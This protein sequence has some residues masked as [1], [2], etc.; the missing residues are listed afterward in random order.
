MTDG[1]VTIDHAAFVA[2]ERQAHVNA[3][4]IT[5]LQDLIPVAEDRLAWL[6]EDPNVNTENVIVAEAIEQALAAIALAEQS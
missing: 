3:A 1:T 2:M 4:L 5:A 6:D